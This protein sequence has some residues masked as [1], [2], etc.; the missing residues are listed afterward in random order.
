MVT[1]DELKDN[2]EYEDLLREITE[3]CEKFGPVLTATLPRPSGDKDVPG[4]GYV[5]VHFDCREA[6]TKA[7]TAL[8]GRS[9]DA[10]VVQATF[11]DE[12][13][14]LDGELNVH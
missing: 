3:E 1:L 8:D 10:R 6:A 5:F 9:F 7:K 11:F 2:E 4:L 12:Q 13:K 14:F